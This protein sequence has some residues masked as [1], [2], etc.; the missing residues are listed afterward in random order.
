MTAQTSSRKKVFLETFDR[1]F[2]TTLKL[3]RAFPADQP[4][5]KPHPKTK[6]ARELAWTFVMERGLGLK[7][8]NDEL[9]KGVPSGSKPPSAPEKWSD[10]IAALEKANA[11]YRAVIAAASDEDLAKNVHFFTAPKTMGELSRFNWIWFLL[12]DEIHHRGQLSVYV[13]A[14]GAKVPSIYGPTADEPW[15]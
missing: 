2:A 9:A 15:M 14:S 4:D 8:W 11:D 1:E 3:L 10:I 5:F 13:R 6:S 7:V 12:H